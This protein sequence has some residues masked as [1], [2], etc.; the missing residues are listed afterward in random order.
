VELAT[1]AIAGNGDLVLVLFKSVGS[2]TDT[3]MRN[4][5]TLAALTGLGLVECDFSSYARKVLAGGSDYSIA[6]NTTTFTQ[7]I[8]FVAKVWN[9]AGGVTNNSPVKATVVYRPTPGSADSACTPLGVYDATGSA[10]GGT[11]S[12]TPGALVD[13]A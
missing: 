5:Q 9:P 3:T 4:A 12:F 13:D 7:T 10:S 1:Q 11:Y 8:T 2:A 6:T